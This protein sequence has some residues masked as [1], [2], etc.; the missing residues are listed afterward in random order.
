MWLT[1]LAAMACVAS[2]QLAASADDSMEFAVL[3]HTA[4]YLLGRSGALLQIERWAP[5]ARYH[6]VTISHTEAQRTTERLPSSR[7]R[8]NFCIR[9]GTVW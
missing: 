5:A 3:G 6:L 2:A 8:Y 9:V 7:L 1:M 4:A